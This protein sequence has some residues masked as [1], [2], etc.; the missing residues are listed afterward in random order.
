MNNI[1]IIQCILTGCGC[2]VRLCK[3][4]HMETLKL[5]IQNMHC[6]HCVRTIT[7]ELK[8][9]PGVEDVKGELEN[10]SITVQYHPPATMEQIQARLSEINYPGTVQ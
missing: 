6:A 7:M 3:G 8:E 1:R 2:V 4:V 5:T 10:N 9:V